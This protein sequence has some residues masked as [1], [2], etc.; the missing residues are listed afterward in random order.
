MESG[1][2]LVVKSTD[3]TIVRMHGLARRYIERCFA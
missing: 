2:K 1:V 3:T